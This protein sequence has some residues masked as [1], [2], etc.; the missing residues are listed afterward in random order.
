M[1]EVGPAD[2]GGIAVVKGAPGAASASSGI[3]FTNLHTGQHVYGGSRADGSF[4]IRFFAPPGSYIEV[5]HDST[6]AAEEIAANPATIVRAPLP[7]AADGTFVALGRAEESSEQF[8]T[9]NE[10]R[11]LGLGDRGKIWITGELTDRNWQAGDSFEITGTMKLYSRNA[12]SYELDKSMDG[13]FLLERVFDE[14]GSQEIANPI[15]MSH[16]LTPTGMPIEDVPGD[17]GIDQQV[18]G[19]LIGYPV[20]SE[21]ALS[22]PFSLEANWTTDITI[23]ENLP[24]GVYS[25][26][27]EFWSDIETP[28]TL[29]FEDVYPE[30]FSAYFTTGGSTLI[31]VGSPAASRLSWVLGINDFSNGSRGTIATVDRDRIQIAGRQTANSDTYILPRDHPT[32]GNRMVYRLE[33]FVPLITASN[34]GWLSPPTVPV[35]F[36]SGNLAVR[37]KQPDGSVANLGSAPF[38]G[39]YAQEASTDFGKDMDPGNS[40]RRYFGLTTLSDQ[41]D[42]SFEQYGRHEIIMTGAVDDIFG[43]SLQGGGMYE[44]YVARKLDMET[45]VFPG[46]P[47]EVGD[48]FSPTVVVQPGIPADVRITIKHYPM[49]D[50][51]QVVSHNIVGTANRFGYFSGDLEDTFTFDT[52]GEYRVDIIASYEDSNRILWMG[53]ETWASVVETPN[54]GVITHGLRSRHGNGEQ[55]QWAV[56]NQVNTSFSHHLPFPFHSGDIVWHDDTLFDPLHI[57]SVPFITVQDT[58]GE[59]YGILRDRN[60]EIGNPYPGLEDEMDT[61]QVLLWSSTPTGMSAIFEFDQPET[62]VSY[63]YTTASRPGIRV[64]EMVTE[65]NNDESY[66]RFEGRYFD[67]SGVGPN[68]DQPNDFKFQ[69]GGAVF[70]APWLDYYFYG[71]YGSLWVLLPN[72]DPVGT[73]V[74]PPFQG[75]GGGPGGGPIMT[76]RGKDIDMFFHLGGVRPGSILEVGDVAS[77]A[78]QIAPTLPS[79]VEIIVM[80]PTGTPINISGQSNKVGYFYD[81]LSDFI[82]NEAGVWT[83]NISVRH[84]GRTSAGQVQQPYP[85]G[86]V[87]GSRSGEFYF[88]VVDPESGALTVDLPQTSWVE[89]GKGPIDLHLLQT[90]DLSNVNLHHTTIM[91]G[92][93]LEEGMSDTLTYTYD[94][95]LL[96]QTF[97]NIDLVDEDARYGVDTITMSFLVSGEDGDGKTVYRARQILLQG[98]ELLAPSQLPTAD[99]PIKINAGHSGAWFNPITSG[100]GQFIDIE[101]EKQFM[102][103][104]WFTYTD[105]ASDTPNEQQW[106]TAQGNYKDKVAE[107]E[108]YETLGG[109]FDDPR[110]VSN[111]L[112][113]TVTV[114]FSDC[115]HGLMTYHIDKEN[116]YG[117]FSLQRVIDGSGN[118][119]EG[120]SEN[121]TQAVDINAGMDGA[122]FNSDTSGQGFFIDSHPDPEGDNF[123][124]VSWFT[125]GDDTASGQRWLTA[126]GGFEGSTATIDVHETTG[127]SFDD[128][129]APD[130]VKE[131][132]MTID[133]TDC[134]NATLSYSLTDDVLEGDIALTRVVSGGQALC[135]ELAGAD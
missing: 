96:N 91:P 13:R 79:M 54:S 84:E 95:P 80:P 105:A 3:L 21:L 119:C 20:F 74:M 98:E 133:F 128:P 112:V 12:P 64:R 5:R 70:R 40:P 83:V 37:V 106:Y 42:F 114:S 61:G 100:Q 118:V 81:S 45:G 92:F 63:A 89:P 10:A 66:W 25:L 46:T 6:G 73:R 108:L 62:L 113:G 125:Y 48:T 129:Q 97:P 116:L 58:K 41:F 126:Q 88:Y 8:L 53:S 47:F 102:F 57:A 127:G 104:S 50:P 44:V 135:E 29:H 87:L 28:K 99:D 36:P 117:E 39:P 121:A 27:I 90:D 76:L 32:S 94:A 26:V 11:I 134:N 132:T 19:V 56:M 23:P 75:N 85:T 72:D 101:P 86:D 4:A 51:D 38:L 49:S 131:G 43:N 122:W 109:R 14:F 55:F 18:D 120:L 24:D 1:I 65:R 9:N 78:G 31:S 69:F 123:I 30:N 15:G 115:S 107:L 67:Q 17:N 60:E 110:E 111:T 130:T 35:K 93:V 71:A 77:F 33:P 16:T 103:I 2:G 34:R 22:G 82:V 7:G 59:L 52:P 68:G 124:F